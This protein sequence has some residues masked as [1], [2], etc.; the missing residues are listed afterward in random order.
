MKEEV[1][2]TIE[3][4][5]NDGLNLS[6]E[7]IEYAFKGIKDEEQLK[8]KNLLLRGENRYL[9]EMFNDDIDEIK[10][11][12]GFYYEGNDVLYFFSGTDRETR[13]AFLVINFK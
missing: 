7:E 10:L 6:F 12:D 1:K 5:K 4:C 2:R 13:Y 3:I 8:L 9:D 11:E